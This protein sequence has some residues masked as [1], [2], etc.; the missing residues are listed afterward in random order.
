MLALQVSDYLSPSPTV[1]VPW[2]QGLANLPTPSW[3]LSPEPLGLFPIRAQQRPPPCRPPAIE[4]SA[5]N[6]LLADSRTWETWASD[7][8][9][10]SLVQG[11]VILWLWLIGQ[12]CNVT[13]SARPIQGESAGTSRDQIIVWVCKSIRAAEGANL[14]TKACS[15]PA[16]EPAPALA[17]FL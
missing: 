5:F 16:R 14:L 13:Q 6:G 2:L 4:R 7:F 10:P 15:L 8:K 17:N 3:Q 1:S 12:D 11:D 9:L